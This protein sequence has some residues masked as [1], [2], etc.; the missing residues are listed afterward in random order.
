MTDCVLLDI[1]EVLLKLDFG[2]LIRHLGFREA[3]GIAG[4]MR[5]LNG[6]ELYDR[7][8]RGAIAQDVFHAALSERVLQQ[9]GREFH[10]TDFLRVWNSIIVGP[11]PGIERIVER[12]ASRVPLYALTNTNEAHMRHV[13]V[14]YGW[15][16][17]FR[18]IL[19][20]NELQAR[21]PERRIYE[22]AAQATGFAPEQILFVDDR[23]EN[24]EGARE[25]GMQAELCQK[26]P[27]DLL[28]ILKRYKLD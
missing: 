4:A 19:T 14:K 17:H 8:E 15:L 10:E 20:S 7:F 5:V 23:P 22:L 3:D 12:L 13:T 6:W 24:V 28:T 11:V 27:T 16:G 21:K 25:A 9:T 26:S 1:G 18:K 2:P